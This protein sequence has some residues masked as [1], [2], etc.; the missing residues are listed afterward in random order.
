MIKYRIKSEQEFITE[1]GTEW[2]S[3][4]RYKW[5]R[6]GKMDHLFNT[7]LK[8]EQINIYKRVGEFMYDDWC[9]SSDMIKEINVINYNDKKVLVYD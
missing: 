2:R 3:K 1:F 7:L 4:V 8:E 5:N 9:I 6:I